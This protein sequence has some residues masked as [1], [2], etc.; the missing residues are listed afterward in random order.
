[1]NK[2]IAIVFTV[3]I[4]LISCVSRKSTLTTVNDFLYFKIDSCNEKC[5]DFY[6]N[7]IFVI[8]EIHLRQENTIPF[9]ALIRYLNKS[10]NVRKIVLEEGFSRAKIVNEYINSGDS[11]L[12]KFLSRY[13]F[14]PDVEFYVSL[15]QY[16]K[17]LPA[18]KK[19]SI[20]SAD[21]DE[22]GELAFVIEY[23]R[24]LTP[25]K[26]PPDS[27]KKI[28]DYLRI[29][30]KYNYFTYRE[31]ETYLSK[32]EASIEQNQTEYEKYYGENYP[33]FIEAIRRWNFSKQF[34]NYN[35]NKGYDSLMFFK[36]E[37]QI[38]NNIRDVLNKAKNEKI[39]AIFGFAHIGNDIALANKEPNAKT[40][41]H[42]LENDSTRRSKLKVASI[43]FI[44]NN[45][46]NRRKIKEEFPFKL[47]NIYKPV[48]R[49][50][51]TYIV[52]L[53][54]NDSIMKRFTENKIQ[55]LLL[56]NK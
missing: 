44:Y 34:F 16:N 7:N 46:W 17:N 10:C 12:L 48:A 47:K 27:L 6:D 24:I 9:M 49:I 23:L 50:P 32:I 15:W 5:Y 42:Y 28:V 39:M 43:S 31:N 11:L 22:W 21:F 52:K 13:G 29:K 18:D 30:E 4:L 36:R 56:Y 55:Y 25:N 2:K 40:F 41:V 33:L 54:P 8:G 53:Y 38:A 1:M 26:V 45:F 20:Y 14:K 19:L 37:N 3:L 51:G 35:P